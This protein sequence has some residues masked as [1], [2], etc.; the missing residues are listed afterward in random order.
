MQT[1][2][3]SLLQISGRQTAA[4]KNQ[5]HSNQD[6]PRALRPATTS[7]ALC[8]CEADPTLTEHYH[9]LVTS[10]LPL[11]CL[12]VHIELNIQRLTTARPAL[13]AGLLWDHL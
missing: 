8:N 9:R 4:Q 5:H 12:Q 6:P 3:P 1:Q 10:S 7:R 11:L 2:Q 13:H